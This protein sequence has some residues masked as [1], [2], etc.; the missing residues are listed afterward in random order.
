MPE[1]WQSWFKGKEFSTDW[2][3]AHYPFWCAAL[4][5]LRNEKIE[6]LEIGSWEGRSAIFFLEY[7]T[8]SSITCVDTFAGGVEHSD[9]PVYARE[10]PLVEQRF[11]RNLAAFNGRVTKLKGQSIQ[12]FGKIVP[13]GTKFDVIYIDGSHERDIV[14]VD[15]LMAW[16]M[17]KVGGYLI[18]DDYA[19]GDG[20]AD[21]NRVKS[22]I[23]AFLKWHRDEYKT[24]HHGYQIIIQRTR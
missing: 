10:L 14:M 5:D 2:T 12:A 9:H 8:K 17:L 18:W 6:I 16:A 24:L 21:C 11:D 7:L 3:S 15:T 22:A 23:D 13:V 1:G 19:G 4:K 20:L